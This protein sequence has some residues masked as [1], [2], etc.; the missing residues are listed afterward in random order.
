MNEKYSSDKGSEKGSDKGSE[1]IGNRPVHEVRLGRIKATVWANASENGPWHSVQVSR[2]YKD[3]EQQWRSS[4]RFHRDD[5]PLVA[6]VA[7]RAHSWIYEQSERSLAERG[8]D[9][10]QEDTDCGGDW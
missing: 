6:K 2:L 3:G 10:R 8:S 4:E 1:K 9:G 7:D 5:L